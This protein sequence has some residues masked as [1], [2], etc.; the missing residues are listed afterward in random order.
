MIQTRVQTTP[1][2]N[3]IQQVEAALA[4]LLA[5]SS[6]RGFYGEAGIKLNVQDGVIQHIRV[7]TERMIK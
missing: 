4:K 7:A 5:D 2:M 1:Q 6:Q 3:K